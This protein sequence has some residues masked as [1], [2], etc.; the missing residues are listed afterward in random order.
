MS[1]PGDAARDLSRAERFQASDS[2][3]ERRRSKWG[4]LILEAGGRGVP[5]EVGSRFLGKTCFCPR[6]VTL[7]VPSVVDLEIRPWR[8]AGLV[9]LRGWGLV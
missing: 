3:K 5:K 8:P 9:L 7:K 1:N 6:G 4:N 2:M